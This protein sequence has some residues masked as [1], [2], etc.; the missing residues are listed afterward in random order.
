MIVTDRPMVAAVYLI[1]G[2]CLALLE[3]AP[4]CICHVMTW[5]H[6]VI[7][8]HGSLQDMDGVEGWYAS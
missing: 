6:G 3:L 7:L 8:R 5:H 2:V 4:R 1:F